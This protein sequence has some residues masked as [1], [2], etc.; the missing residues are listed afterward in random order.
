MADLLL[1]TAAI[2]SNFWKELWMA[3]NETFLNFKKVKKLR[4]RTMKWGGIV[5][6]KIF[7]IACLRMKSGY[8]KSGKFFTTSQR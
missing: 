3:W 8:N 1:S 4:F 7:N 2:W 5:S 6:V